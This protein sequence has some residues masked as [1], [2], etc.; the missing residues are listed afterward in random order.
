MVQ[1]L[2]EHVTGG[3]QYLV[4]KEPHNY[5]VCI[6]TEC[7]HVSHKDLTGVEFF[8]HQYSK[9][10]WERIENEEKWEGGRDGGKWI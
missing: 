2:A 6:D 5:T 4:P 7:M 3:A 8:F 1:V 10:L 9:Q